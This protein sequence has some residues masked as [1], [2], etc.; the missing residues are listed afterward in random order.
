[1]KKFIINLGAVA[2]AFIIGLA[3]NSACAKHDSK[4]DPAGDGGGT[5]PVVTSPFKVIDGL[6]FGPDGK[7]Y[8]KLVSVTYEFDIDYYRTNYYTRTEKYNYDDKGRLIKI[9]WQF[10]NNYDD[11][12]YNGSGTYEYIDS[13]DGFVTVKETLRM[14]GADKIPVN[15]YKYIKD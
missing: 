6:T 12:S 13:A 5:T 9:E 4:S 7:V 14:D 8:N 15:T 10:V 11:T 1:M 3:I 2:A